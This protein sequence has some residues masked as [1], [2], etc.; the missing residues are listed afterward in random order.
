LSSTR[1]GGLAAIFATAA[2]RGGVFEALRA[3]RV[4][5]TNGPR[6][7]VLAN[8]A[9]KPPGSALCVSGECSPE[10]P[11]F[12]PPLRLSVRVEATGPLDRIEV[13][14]AGAVVERIAAAGRRSLVLELPIEDPAGGEY[15]YLRVLQADGGLALISPFFFD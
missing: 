4:Y 12:E 5:A 6:I 1:G 15:L 13:V 11:R 2:T 7:L 14:R 3:R 9:G 8:L 10:Q